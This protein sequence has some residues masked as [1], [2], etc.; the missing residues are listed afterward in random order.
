MDDRGGVKLTVPGQIH[1]NAPPGGEQSMF[2]DKPQCAAARVL[3]LLVAETAALDAHRST[4]AAFAVQLMIS[5]GMAVE[6]YA[7]PG[8]VLL[9][10]T[11]I[12]LLIF[13]TWIVCGYLS[14]LHD[15]RPGGENGAARL[16]RVLSYP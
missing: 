11:Y 16:C 15:N 6:V 3:S 4:Q 8:P 1:G 5:H 12:S 14:A 13:E 2:A 7:S 10:I 9:F